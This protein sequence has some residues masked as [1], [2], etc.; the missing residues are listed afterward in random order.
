LQMGPHQQLQMGPHQQLQMGPHQQLRRGLI[1]LE[2]TLAYPPGGDWTRE[3]K[4]EYRWWLKC[5]H[6]E[7]QAAMPAVTFARGFWR[8]LMDF[9]DAE[10]PRQDRDKFYAGVAQACADLQ[11]VTVHRPWHWGFIQQQPE[12]MGI[13]LE[14]GLHPV[15]FIE[16]SFRHGRLVAH[17][18]ARA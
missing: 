14:G 16:Y 3:D 5:I 1:S 13:T 2:T 8:Q 4:S 6:A 7:L 10:I 9:A 11:T 15:A 12:R 18:A 17:D